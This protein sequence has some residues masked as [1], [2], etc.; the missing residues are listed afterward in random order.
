ML[1]W[2]AV[3]LSPLLA[4]GLT[5]LVALTGCGSDPGREGD[6]GRTEPGS[7]LGAGGVPVPLGVAIQDLV[8]RYPA[9]TT[10]RLESGVHRRQSIVPRSGDVYL[11]ESGAV[12]DGEDAI[13]VAFHGTTGIDS[14]TI[15]GL[16]IR[17]YV[18]P[19]QWA[20]IR[21]V[22]TRG[23]SVIQNDIHHNTGG[24]RLGDGM[25]VLGNHIHHNRQTGIMGQGDG[26]LVE[27][28][29]V[30]HNNAD[31]GFDPAESPETYEAGGMKITYSTGITIRLN[32]VHH[33]GLAGIWMDLDNID[34]LIEGNRVEDNLGQ[35]IYYEVSY[36]GVIRDNMIARNGARGG[37]YH[38]GGVVVSASSDVEV[39][40][41]QILDNS[42]GVIG[43]Q[44]ERGSGAHGPHWLANLRVHGNVIHQQSG[45]SGVVR[46]RE[47]GDEVF[48]RQNRFERNHYVLG[49]EP[50]YFR[51][52]RHDLSES[53]W[54]AYG[55]D[56]GST[57]VR[58]GGR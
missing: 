38:R 26:A 48:E 11:G 32:H 40:G 23:W 8:D 37:W 30:D 22:D 43:S 18:P 50:H 49:S 1:H 25:Q 55:Q 41:N 28:N 56:A 31:L 9:G 6:P 35:G 16:E 36:R 21:G 20:A 57:F 10:F 52:R 19:P 39:T 5:V 17:H 12:L 33:N 29:E 4:S 58:E 27:G 45:V 14:V 7:T 34:V 2:I 46:D 51:W 42:M 54:L 47:V 15:Q 24:V 3:Q 13:D 53:E 44:T